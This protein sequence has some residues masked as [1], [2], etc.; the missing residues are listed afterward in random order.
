MRAFGYLFSW[1]VLVDVKEVKMAQALMAAYKFG[2]YV[3]KPDFSK[4]T[5]LFVIFVVIV[6]FAMAATMMIVKTFEK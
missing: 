4:G 6:G 1:F 5:T 2:T 3:P